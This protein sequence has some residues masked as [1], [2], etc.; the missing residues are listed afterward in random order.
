MKR[1]GRPQTVVDNR[2]ILSMVKKSPFTTSSQENT[3]QEVSVSLSKSTIKKR[4]HQ[5][6]Y[7]RFTTRCKQGQIRLCQKTYKK[8]QTFGKLSFGRLK[9]RSTCTRMMGRKKVWRRLGTAHDPKH[10]SSSV[11]HGGA[12]WCTS[13]HGFQWH[14]VTGVYWWCDSP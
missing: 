11:K 14:W 10:T 2:M 4:L 12:V 13:V 8:S 9:L 5:S 6:K 1:S 3:L 7:R